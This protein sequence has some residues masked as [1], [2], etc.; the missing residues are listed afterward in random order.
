MTLPI[1]RYDIA[2]YLAVSAETVSRSLTELK[3][4]GLIKMSGTRV[5][6]IIDREALEECER[7]R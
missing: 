3:Q 6:K 2:E 1:T 7:P 5:V 4:R